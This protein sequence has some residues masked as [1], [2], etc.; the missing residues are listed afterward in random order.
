MTDGSVFRTQ[1]GLEKGIAAIRNLRERYRDVGVKNRRKV[2]NYELMET[3]ELGHQVAVAEVI[4]VS[5]LHRE[6]SRGA[7]SREDFPERDDEKFLQHTLAFRNG[8]GPRIAYK[9][10]KITKFQPQKR[11]Y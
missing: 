8:G 6:E 4:L 5:A 3:M 9:P 7:H 10:V 1:S 11:I 2:F